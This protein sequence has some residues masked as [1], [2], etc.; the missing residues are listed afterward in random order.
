MII[1]QANKSRTPQPAAGRH[2]ELMVELAQGAQRLIQLIEAESSGRYDGLGQTFWVQSDPI[3][4]LTK[5]LA[6]L[7][8]ERIAI[9]K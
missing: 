4:Q 6:T 3:L 5:K 9:L 7:A 2:R 1:I 8:E